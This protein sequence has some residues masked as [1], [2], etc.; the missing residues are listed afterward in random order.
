MM[1]KQVCKT[2][3]VLEWLKKIQTQG[4]LKSREKIKNYNSSSLP[5]RLCPIIGKIP[6]STNFSQVTSIMSQS[7]LA[8][9]K[10]ALPQAWSTPNILCPT[11]PLPAL[12]N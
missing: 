2:Q 11:K 8:H 5:L 9:T 3:D 4:Q 6:S 7:L 12:N 1:R 10:Q